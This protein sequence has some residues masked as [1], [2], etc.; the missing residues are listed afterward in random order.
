[1]TQYT[2]NPPLA[3]LAL[4]L[5]ENVRKDSLLSVRGQ[6][7]DYV[8]LQSYGMT[9]ITIKFIIAVVICTFNQNEVNFEVIFSW[10]YNT[11]IVLDLSPFYC[12]LNTVFM[13]CHVM[14]GFI[15][16]FLLQMH[17]WTGSSLLPP[18]WLVVVVSSLVLWIR[19][20]GVLVKRF[21][22]RIEL[23]PESVCT[24]GK[25]AHTFS[26]STIPVLLNEL[27]P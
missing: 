23:K 21:C 24:L 2:A 17:P 6:R 26:C 22:V 13:A 3:V 4:F 5:W 16:T 27:G 12:H 19:M 10:C 20:F 1:M 8:I 25:W 7:Q 11:F 9:Y 14:F 18:L 15:W